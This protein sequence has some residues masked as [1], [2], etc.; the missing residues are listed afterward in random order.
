VISAPGDYVLAGDCTGSGAFAIFIT[1]S[2]VELALAG[3]TI[4]SGTPP[5]EGAF[6]IVAQDVSGLHIEGPGTIT[7]FLNA[8]V[9]FAN[10]SRSSIEQVTTSANAETGIDLRGSSVANVVAGNTAT[11]NGTGI[12]LEDDSTGNRIV[13]NTALSNGVDLADTHAGC[14]Q[15]KWKG[16]VF[17]TANQSCI[18]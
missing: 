16:N 13:G 9:G 4:T 15:N 2:K 10:V 18:H 5:F 12:L 11:N 1:A 8:G 6:G 17:D 14:D 3:H 7:G